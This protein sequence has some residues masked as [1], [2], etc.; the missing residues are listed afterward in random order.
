MK[1]IYPLNELAVPLDIIERDGP[2][3]QF[4][5]DAAFVTVELSNGKNVTGVLLLLPNFVIAV[6]GEKDLPFSP[7]DI[8]KITQTKEDR[9]KRS[10]SEWSFF[11]DPSEFSKRK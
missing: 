2:F 7:K 5:Q 3:R 6:E 11:Y 10:S 9:N 1:N 4:K 8:V